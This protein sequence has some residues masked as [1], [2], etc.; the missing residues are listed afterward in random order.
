MKPAPFD[1]YAPGTVEEAVAL[2][3]KLEDDDIDAK[4][5]AGGQSLM[6]MLG[7]R[8]AR[9][10]ALVDLG[11]IKA[12]KY[13]RE[14]DGVIAIGAMT[15]KSA[16]EDSDLIKA[17]QPL[18]HAAT[19]NIGHRQ[20]RN[21]GTVGGSFAHADPAA[22]Y[23]AIAMA[24]GMEMVVAGPDGERTVPADEFYVS[25]LTTDIDC[26]EVLTEVRMPVMPAGT[27]W[28]FQEMARRV[29][30]LALAGVAVT[31]RLQGGQCADV[32]IAVFGVNATAARLSDAEQVVNGKSPDEALF[33]QAG[34]VAAAEI[35]QP[36]SD[37]HA[38]AE[39]R[40]ALIETLVA[41]CLAQAVE[42]AG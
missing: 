40:R 18:F 38:S 8:M 42:R 2:L 1:Y 25:F 6:P 13:I 27:G 29:G 20:I 35:D 30:D 36:I 15:S 28:A 16:A 7:L 26:T 4:I 19:E 12:L 17:K 24:L 10:E 5:I 3:A 39:Y 37:V 31:L 23:G 9:P 22:E 14:E 32:V 33:A 41:R 34:K 11:K 21:Q